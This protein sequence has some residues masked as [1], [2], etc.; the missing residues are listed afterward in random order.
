MSSADQVQTVMAALRPTVGRFA[1][2]SM[3]P[4]AAIPYAIHSTR[5]ASVFTHTEKSHGKLKPARETLIKL[6]AAGRSQL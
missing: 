4:K 1:R 2:S 6:S 5:A 3:F